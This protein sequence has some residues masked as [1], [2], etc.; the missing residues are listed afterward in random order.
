MGS[1]P[2]SDTNFLSFLTLIE[3][4]LDHLVELICQMIKIQILKIHFY[5]NESKLKIFNG[6]R[7]Q[8]AI[9]TL[10]KY[11]QILFDYMS[12]MFTCYSETTYDQ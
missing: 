6:E 8:Q 3:M 11:H 7:K 5:R 1:N 2:T 10:A 4:I 9:T 12:I